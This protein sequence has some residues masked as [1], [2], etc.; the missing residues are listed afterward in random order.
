[1]NNVLSVL[2]VVLK[3]AV[4]WGLIDRVPCAIRLLKT[5]KTSA[6]Y[7]DFEPFERLVEAAQRLDARTTLIVLLGGEAG[8]RCGEIMALEWKD[9]DLNKRQLTVERSDWKG[10]VTSTKAGRVRHV[11]MRVRLAQMLQQHRHLRGRRV[12]FCSHSA[13]R[14]APTR[15]IQ[16]LAG[17][18]DLSTTQPYMHVSP[19]A[20]ED[21]IRLLDEPGFRRGD[22][23]ER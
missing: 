19:A 12:L 21:A 18:Q 15:A 2:N 9:V 22:S 5:P 6:Q 11:P 17:H 23:L 20:V 7:H 4:E 14:G 16:T 8:L 10:H 1:V 13:M 3:S